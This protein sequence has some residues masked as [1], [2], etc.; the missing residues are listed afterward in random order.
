VPVDLA[1]TMVNE[2]QAIDIL[3]A[4]D[5]IDVFESSSLNINL[6]DSTV[7]PSTVVIHHNL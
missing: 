4:S 2:T 5:Y 1:Q 7:K 6:C 3:H